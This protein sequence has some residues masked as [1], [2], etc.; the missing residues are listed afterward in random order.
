MKTSL[1]K[2]FGLVG[3]LVALALVLATAFSLSA[4]PAFA[5]QL[6]RIG[7]D[8]ASV[9]SLG[10]SVQASGSS[11]DFADSWAAP[12]FD[13]ESHEPDIPTVFAG[14]NLSWKRLAGEGYFDTM[15]KISNEGWSS[16]SGGTVVV[17]TDVGH[18]DALSASG[19]AGLSGAPVL[20]TSPN[21]LPAQTRAELVR[22][23]PTRVIIAGG[24]KAV[25]NSVKDAIAKA[26]PKASVERSYGQEATDTAAALNRKY[27]GKQSTVAILAT[28]QGF[29][30]ALSAAPVAYAKHYPVFLA[31]N[32]NTVSWNTV[33]AMKACGIKQVIVVGGTAVVSD[34]IVATLR[35]NGITLK[36]RLSGDTAYDTSNAIAKWAVRN[37]MKATNAGAATGRLYY[38][39]LCGAALCGKYNSALV[40]VDQGWLAGVDGFIRSYATDVERGYIFGGTSV[41]SEYLASVL[42][43]PYSASDSINITLISPGSAWSSRSFTSYDITGDGNADTIRFV[44]DKRDA[45]WANALKIYVNGRLCRTVKAAS[46]FGGSFFNS[47]VKVKYLRMAGGTPFLFVK[48]SGNNA[49]GAHQL[50]QYRGGS[51]ACVASNADLPA[52]F[53]NHRQIDDAIASGNKVSVKYS[54]MTFAAGGTSITYDFTLSRGVLKRTG[55]VT[56]NVAYS[57]SGS[58]GKHYCAIRTNAKTYTNVYM[59]KAKFTVGSG[60]RVA[61]N[62]ACIRW[63]SLFFELKTTSGKTG[64]IKAPTKYVAP[65]GTLLS[66]TYLAG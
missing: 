35:Y 2:S 50:L 36:T 4:A 22:I 30:D 8:G 48:C 27:F 63:G 5:D 38:D 12:I 62:Q 3:L 17:A 21:R 51:F 47:N 57:V 55:D 13:S 44:L 29:Q 1:G 39:A 58:S 26:L 52:G 43:N 59:N 28:S 11:S 20:I 25:S 42:E 19:V 31:D 9:L 10:D 45:T 46:E 6:E 56:S 34:K 14:V 60:E 16:G 37:G 40:L 53:G 32:K 65:Y 23:N 18:W 33:S 7:G 24:A 54:Y 61:L 64:W 66:G 49:D 41:V 15:Q